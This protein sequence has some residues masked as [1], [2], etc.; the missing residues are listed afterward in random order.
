M[1]VTCSLCSLCFRLLSWLHVFTPVA[2]STIH[3]PFKR[4]V[5]A[6]GSLSGQPAEA[7]YVLCKCFL[8]GQV[9]FDIPGT[10]HCL[11]GLSRTKHQAST[12]LKSEHAANEISRSAA[13]GFSISNTPEGCHLESI[14]AFQTA[15]PS[16]VS[17]PSCK[18]RKDQKRLIDLKKKHKLAYCLRP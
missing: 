18:R 7:G 13:K 6:C 2:N 8:H 3:R 11:S 16:I 15:H 17:T 14:K 5:L 12:S 1:K 9:E 10:K 4:E